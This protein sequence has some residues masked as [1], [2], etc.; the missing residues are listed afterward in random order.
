[1]AS[2]SPSSGKSDELPG[3]GVKHERLLREWASTLLCGGK[4]SNKEAAFTTAPVA[5]EP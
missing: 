1:M 2:Y 3:P 4:E 5:I